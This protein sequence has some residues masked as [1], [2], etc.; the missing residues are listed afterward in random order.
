MSGEFDRYCDKILKDALGIKDNDDEYIKKQKEYIQVLEKKISLMNSK[1]DSLESRL[2][3]S[4]TS[5]KDMIFRKNKKLRSWVNQ[6]TKAIKDQTKDLDKII[7]D[8][9]K[10]A[11]V[12]VEEIYSAKTYVLKNQVVDGY[13]NLKEVYGTGYITQILFLSPSN[14]YSIKIM[15]DDAIVLEE[16]YTYI[17]TKSDYLDNITADLDV[18]TY[19]LDIKDKHFQKY[20][21]IEITTNSSITFDD[22]IIQYSIRKEGERR[23]V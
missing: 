22:L 15:I 12:K 1:I 3:T 16:S 6:Q 8:Q 19:Y 5:M 10:Q 7:E 11:I 18:A 23:N 2:G 4:G 14:D 9:I 21:S 17:A 20:F 13:Y